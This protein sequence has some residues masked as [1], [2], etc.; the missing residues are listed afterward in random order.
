MIHVQSLKVEDDCPYLTP[1]FILEKLHTEQDVL[2]L[3]VLSL[4]NLLKLSPLC[5]EVDHVDKKQ[6][7]NY[8]SEFKKRSVTV[9]DKRFFAVIR[10]IF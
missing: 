9:T 1:E 6:T 7:G 4:S 2:G 10:D 3:P 8:L 5:D